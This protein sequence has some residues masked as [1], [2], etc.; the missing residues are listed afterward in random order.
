MNQILIIGAGRSATSLISYMLK[1][2]EEQG[3]YII[4]A[5]TDLEL[6]QK[7]IDGHPNG[8]AVWLD[9]TKVND[10]K[11]LIVRAALVISLLPAHLHLEV[12]HDCIRL[13]KHLIT[14]SYVSKELYRLG[15]EARDRELIFMGEMGLDPGVD[16]MS[17]MRHLNNIRERGGKVLKF[18]SHTGGLI[19]P[20]SD[21][22]PWHYKFTWN[23]RNVVLAGQGTAQYLDS[24]KLKFIPYSR[25]FGEYEMIKIPGFGPL[26][27][28]PNRDSLLYSDIY[29]LKDVPTIL[30][31]TLRHVGFCDAWNALIKIGLTDGSF[32]ILKSGDISYHELM[33]GYTRPLNTSGSVKDRIAL[34]LNEEPNSEV[35]HKL[36][37]LGL[38]RKKK[39]N[40]PNATPALILE[41]LLK[42]KWALQEDDIDMVIM[43]HEFEYEL[44]GKTKHLTS[45]L[46][47]RGENSQETAM[48]KLVGIPLGICAKLLMQGKIS[49][50]GVQIPVMKEVYEPVLNELEADYGV[51]FQD[52]LIDIG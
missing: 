29:G 40:L 16:H 2:S 39:I 24:G 41:H 43:H 17:A 47:M 8:R 20:E 14:A 31:S 30:R 33:D 36:E 19:A 3:W 32:P 35:M 9:V 22:N 38:F 7:K 28:Y 37:W 18:K 6:A 50:K 27:A 26:E 46:V 42:E 4:V 44:E 48:A 49:S 15:D 52:Q 34:L 13:N 11:D 5:D 1:H 51:V 12:A 21:D 45:T 10:R 23:P 25:L